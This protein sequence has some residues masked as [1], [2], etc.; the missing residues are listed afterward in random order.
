MALPTSVRLANAPRSSSIQADILALQVLHPLRLVDLEPAVSLAPAIIT[1]LR[2]PR[3]RQA[4]G[5]GLPCAIDTS[6]WRSSVTICSAPNLF[7][8]MT[9]SFPSSFSHN[10]WS[11]KARSGQIADIMFAIDRAHI[12]AERHPNKI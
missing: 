6:I 2:Y 12:T 9:G 7:F 4:T 3:S 10:A 5:V 1:L 11:K 8:G